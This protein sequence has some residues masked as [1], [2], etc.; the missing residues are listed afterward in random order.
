[1]SGIVMSVHS[2]SRC[3][4]GSCCRLVCECLQRGPASWICTGCVTWPNHTSFHLLMM[5]PASRGPTRLLILLRTTRCFCAPSKRC[6]SA[7]SR[8][9][10]TG[11]HSIL[12]CGN[13]SVIRLPAIHSAVAIIRAVFRICRNPN[14][15]HSSAHEQQTCINVMT[16]GVIRMRGTLLV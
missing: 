11:L 9:Y 7:S 4:F 8:F 6:G 15:C 10:I 14:L 16:V 12:L 3:R 13:I 1:M 2:L 5:V